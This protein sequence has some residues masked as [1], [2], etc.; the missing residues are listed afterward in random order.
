MPNLRCSL[1]YSSFSVYHGLICLASKAAQVFDLA[2]QATRRTS[3]WCLSLVCVTQLMKQI[4]LYRIRTTIE[5]SASGILWF[6][7]ALP[8][9]AE[10]IT[11]N[12]HSSK[13]LI[14]L[15]MSLLWLDGNTYEAFDLELWLLYKLSVLDHKYHWLT[16]NHC[17]V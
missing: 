12:L 13:V 1:K 17:P 11:P 9:I 4:R 3:A 16:D 5:F 7:C 2:K 15:A 10:L 14:V 8:R 6:Q